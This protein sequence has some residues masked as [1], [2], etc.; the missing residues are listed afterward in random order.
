MIRSQQF[1]WLS[2]QIVL[3]ELVLMLAARRMQTVYGE[4]RPEADPR[5][6]FGKTGDAQS[7]EPKFLI[8][9]MTC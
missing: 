3:M 8:P 1:P 7:P 5:P 2:H 9:R 6:V 4:N